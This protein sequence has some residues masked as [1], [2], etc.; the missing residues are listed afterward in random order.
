M[1]FY[2]IAKMLAQ[3]RKILYQIA[4]TAWHI[5]PR[6]G[7]LKEDQSTRRLPTPKSAA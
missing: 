5:L 3:N 4:K 2:M 7:G 1:I 6:G